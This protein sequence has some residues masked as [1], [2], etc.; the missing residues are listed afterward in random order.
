MRPLLERI[1]RGEI[2]PSRIITHRLSPNEAPRGYEAFRDKREGCVKVV[3]IPRVPAVDPVPSP[4]HRAAPPCV[5]KTIGRPSSQ[6][7][8]RSFA[9]GTTVVAL[10]TSLRGDS[11][12][13]MA[14]LSRKD[15]DPGLRPLARPLHF[16]CLMGMRPPCRE[17]DVVPVGANR[18]LEIEGRRLI[19]VELASPAWPG[20][21]VSKADLIAYYLDV[22]D[23]L[24][25]FLRH[26]PTSVVRRS[27]QGPEGWIFEKGP[28]PGLPGWI[29]R[30]HARAEFS[31]THVE[32]VV[33]DER[34]ALAALVNAGC[35]S[36][37]PWSS[38]CP[39]LD[40]PDQMLFDVDPME[41]AFREVRHA[42]LLLRD[43]LARYGIRSW[44]KT[45]GGRGVHVMVPLRPLHSFDEVRAAAALIAQAARTREPKLFTFEVRRSRRRGRI[46]VDV[47]R[48]RRGATL[49]SLFSV[50]PESGLISAPVEWQDLERALY[51]DDFPLSTVQAHAAEIGAPLREFFQH[52]QSLEPLLEAVR[53]RQRRAAV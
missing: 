26:R 19:L 52:P 14:G 42:A 6:Q 48:N 21:R 47:E 3:L 23:A 40:R 50:R 39:A 28:G 37:H 13:P 10:P 36:F 9:R 46:L 2:D 45:S 25:P 4:C 29:P 12:L 7:A 38:T 22:A 53:A 18:L 41:I 11:T 15:P 20:A 33:M 30:C 16:K 35:L 44:V 24:L 49:V 51:P 27:E 5:R 31:F 8:E 32:C 43:L 34:A 1:A 17:R